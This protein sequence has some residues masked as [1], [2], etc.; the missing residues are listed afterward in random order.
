MGPVELDD[1][2]IHDRKEI[3][4]TYLFRIAFQLVHPPVASEDYPVITLASCAPM[5]EYICAILGRVVLSQGRLTYFAH[6]TLSNGFTQSKR[7]MLIKLFVQ[8]LVIA[9]YYKLQNL[10]PEPRSLCCGHSRPSG[11]VELSPCFSLPDF[12]A[13][14]TES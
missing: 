8:F 14:R 2:Q 11:R 6:V 9:T 10:T 3:I 5:K 1:V 4:H 12:R 13:Q 7:L